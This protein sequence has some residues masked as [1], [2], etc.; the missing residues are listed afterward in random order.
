MS[1]GALAPQLLW[2]IRCSPRGPLRKRAPVETEK[3]SPAP[4]SHSDRQG[5]FTVPGVR[6]LFLVSINPLN[7]PNNSYEVSSTITRT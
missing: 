1:Q 7:P 4:H 5:V 2:P 6:V 3:P